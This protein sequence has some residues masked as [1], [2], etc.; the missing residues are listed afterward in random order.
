VELVELLRTPNSFEAEVIAARLRDAGVHAV[1][2]GSDAGGWAPHL[3]WYHGT[4][5]MV[6]EDALEFAQQLLEEEPELPS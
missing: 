1:I 3:A 2:F 5:I 4:R 6:P